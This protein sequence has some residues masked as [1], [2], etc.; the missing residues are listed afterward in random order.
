MNKKVI[1]GIISVIVVVT[2][3]GLV[4]VLQNSNKGKKEEKVEDDNSISKLENMKDKILKNNNYTFSVKLNE[5]NYKIITKNGDSAKIEI[6]D[7]GKEETYIVKNG[8]TYIKTANA[9]EYR[10]YK[11]NITMLNSLENN[12]QDVLKRNCTTGNETIDNKEYK[13]EEYKNTSVFLI[14]YKGNVDERNTVT[15]FYFDGNELIYIK[16]SVGKIDQLLK[17]ELIF[18]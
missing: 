14:N 3:I 15:R 17:V 9:T 2:I 18:K 6:N 5:D 1:I 7:E 10:E 11:N 13:Y 4:L 12:L 8:N 16:T